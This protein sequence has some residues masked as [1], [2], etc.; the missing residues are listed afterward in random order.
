MIGRT[1]SHY[2]ITEKLGEGGM[3]VVYKAR[4]TRLKRFV[5]LKVLPAEKVTDAERKQR[6]IQEARSASAL[7]HPNI[8]TVYDIGQVDGVDFIA[9]E[10]VEGKTLDELIGRKGLKLNETLKYCIQ[11]ADALAK[12]HAAGIVHRDLKPSN[13]MVTPDGLVK[14]L[15]FGLAKLSES[16]A[17][18]PE[19]PTLTA[20]PA[21]ELGHVVGTAAYMSPEQAEGKKVDARSDIFSFGSV[22]Y[23]MLTGRRAFRRDTPSLTLA[24]ILHLEPAPL[25]PETPGE[26]GRIVARCLR[27]DIAR[28]FQHMDDVKVALEELKEESDSGALAPAAGFASKGHGTKLAW[29]AVAVLVL[30][31]AGTGWWLH[32]PAAEA[33]QDAFTAV[34]LTSFPG[35]QYHPSFSPDGNQVAFV[36]QKEGENESQIYVKLVGPGNPIR[37]SGAPYNDCPEWSPDGGSVAF[38]TASAAQAITSAGAPPL[39]QYALVTTPALGGPQ[40]VVAQFPN[41]GCPSWS[42]DGQWLV[43]PRGSGGLGVIQ[44]QGPNSIWA[45]SIATGATR[46]LTSPS[47]KASF[48]DALPAMSPDGH[49]L[50]FVHQRSGDGRIYL[51]SLSGDMQPEGDPRPLTVMDQRIRRIAWM[52]DGAELIYGAG[53]TSATSAL[54][55][56]RA[57]G[58][59]SHRVAGIDGGAGPAISRPRGPEKWPRLAFVHEELDSNIWR[60]AMKGGK[61]GAPEQAVASTRRDFEPRFSP[62]GARLAFT[63][64]RSGYSEVWVSNADG[65][66]PAQVTSMRSITSGCGRWSPD[67]RI[68]AFCSNATGSMQLYLIDPNGGAARRLTN[69]QSHD[70][71]PSWSRD[72][73]W[74]YFASNRTG[75]FEVWKMAAEPNATA[76]Q[77]STHGGYAPVESFDGKTL[78]YVSTSQGGQIMSIPVSGGEPAPLPIGVYT[79]GD[80]DLMPD[81]IA[82]IP[83]A[84][85]QVCFYGFATKQTKTLAD[86]PRGTDFGLTVSP[87]DGSILFTM[88][89]H[90]SSELELVERFR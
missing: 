2:E 87:K 85:K 31:A 80:Y 56:V 57:S 49:T 18:G 27:K 52:P 67:G 60:V 76:I 34:P 66:A 12:A 82:F 39:I 40:R 88:V 13:V 53:S 64:D 70:T 16:A 78:Y 77:L 23:E 81:G 33:P 79:W 5:A 28:R 71:A 59:E 17:P 73:K 21:T 55:R 61:A 11:M 37:I 68:I 36:W 51:L 9:M 10:Y 42:P 4:D 86:L 74:I 83:F 26:L 54:W 7:N 41:I 65:S 1:I 15:D 90:E 44:R 24:A 25:P 20:A 50:A 84:G 35:H 29:I 58:G 45:V 38:I 22:L 46:Q 62:D 14:V 89:D 63:T 6:F 43:F 75:R 69:D 32:K 19:D 3:G 30:S 47:S 48:G 72:G 8:V